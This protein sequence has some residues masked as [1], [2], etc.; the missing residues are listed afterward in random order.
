MKTNKLLCLFLLCVSFSIQGQVYNFP[1]KPGTPE[2][3]KLN[4]YQEM[5]EVC[6]V[7]EKLLSTFEK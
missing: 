5:I 4:S 1:V 6:R 7:P 3:G 2:W